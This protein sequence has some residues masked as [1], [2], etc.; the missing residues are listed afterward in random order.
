MI[1]KIQELKNLSDKELQSLLQESRDKLRT[2]CFEAAVKKLRDSGELKKLR[3]AIARI[4]TL[5]KQ[6]LLSKESL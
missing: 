5:S 4:L 2:L 6:R 3:K 1:M